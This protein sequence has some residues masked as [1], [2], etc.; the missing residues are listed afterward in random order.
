M[1]VFDELVVFEELVRSGGLIDLVELV[2][3]VEIGVSWRLG[4]INRV[5]IGDIEL[6]FEGVLRCGYRSVL[7]VLGRVRSIFENFE[8]FGIYY[9]KYAKKVKMLNVILKQSKHKNV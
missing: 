3:L 6:Y 8:F 2:V 1:V 9:G 5:L 7:V 4:S